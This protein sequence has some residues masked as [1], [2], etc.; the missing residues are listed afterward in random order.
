M[1]SDF[2][3]LPHWNEEET[4]NKVELYTCITKLVKA[5]KLISDIMPRL[6]YILAIQFT[7]SAIFCVV[8]PG[9]VNSV[10]VSEFRVRVW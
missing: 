8:K 10:S 7:Y 1:V 3:C 2:V 5:V 9:K 4:S 6:F